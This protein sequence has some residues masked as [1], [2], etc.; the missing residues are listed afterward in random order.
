MYFP[1]N[2][3]TFGSV[4]QLNRDMKE[5]RFVSYFSYNSG[6]VRGAGGAARLGE[7]CRTDG[8]AIVLVGAYCI[9]QAEKVWAHELG[10]QIGLQ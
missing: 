8:W 10:H 2:I 4:L 6:K 5:T 1:H 9:G 3:T 7:A